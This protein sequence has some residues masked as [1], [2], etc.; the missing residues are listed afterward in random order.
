MLPAASVRVASVGPKAG[1]LF[2]VIVD[3]THV[4]SVPPCTSVSSEAPVAFQQNIS[5]EALVMTEPAGSD[6]RSKRSQARSLPKP[7]VA[8]W[9]NMLVAA[10]ELVPGLPLATCAS[11]AGVS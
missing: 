4:S 7:V 1:W 9:M 11:A 8:L 10:P 3:S 5:S 6:D 2:Q